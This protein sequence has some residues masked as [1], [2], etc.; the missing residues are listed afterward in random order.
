MTA[1]YRFVDALDL[2]DP[3]YRLTTRHGGGTSCYVTVVD[4][5]GHEA[6]RPLPV[7]GA[8]ISEHC[9]T[10]IYSEEFAFTLATLLGV[11]EI[12]GVGRL[13]KLTGAAKARFVRL[14]GGDDYRRDN[15]YRQENVADFRAF[16]ALHADPK[17]PLMAIARVWGPR[18]R[19]ADFL[20]RGEELDFAHPIAR[21]LNAEGPQPTIAPIAL[22]GIAGKASARALA[23]QLSTI[24]V[25]DAL[26]SQRD[27]FTGENIQVIQLPNSGTPPRVQ[28]VA[29]D[30]GDAFEDPDARWVKAYFRR[31]T[32]FDRRVAE[33]LGE[34]HAFL[35]GE[36]PE[37]AGFRSE[38]A[39]IVAL[40]VSGQA[41][42]WA[43]FR[44]NLGLVVGHIA[45]VK[46]DKYFADGD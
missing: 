12:E 39:L 44:R 26:E 10:N 16:T 6:D 1:F 22:P 8:V 35:T 7:W 28:F 4:A 11:P 2:S 23:R 20:L 38:A 34:L 45:A 14:V 33:K 17:E 40:G 13:M 32:R 21:F 37:F 25:I 24:F 18:P 41:E 27:R 43:T 3:R 5:H 9:G 15:K 29:Y 30:N 19:A 42:L 36:R 31:V 46:G